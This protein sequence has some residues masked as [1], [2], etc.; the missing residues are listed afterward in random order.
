MYQLKTEGNNIKEQR[1]DEVASS[2]HKLSTGRAA[3]CRKKLVPPTGQPF[4]TPW[5]P[6]QEGRH[7]VEKG[8]PL[9]ADPFL[10]HAAP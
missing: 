10:R 6:G 9:G 3:W 7:G 5:R 1:E 4:S 8:W 2:K